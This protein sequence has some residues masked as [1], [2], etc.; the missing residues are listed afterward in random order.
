[1]KIEL[2]IYKWWK[3]FQ[4][5]AIRIILIQSSKYIAAHSPLDKYCLEFNSDGDAADGCYNCIVNFHRET[6]TRVR[7]KE[8][9]NYRINNKLQF[10]P[11]SNKINEISFKL[12]F[13]D[14]FVWIF[15]NLNEMA[16][17]NI[18]LSTAIL[19]PIHPERQA[20]FLCSIE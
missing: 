18:Y 13:V 10:L 2:G 3:T 5:F 6:L 14:W 17:K 20:I 12:V 9:K 16:L 7:K 19:K 1:M 11:Q 4:H 8:K 15:A